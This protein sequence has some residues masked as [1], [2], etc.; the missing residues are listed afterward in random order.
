MA[1]ATAIVVRGWDG[2]FLL[3]SLP[4]AFTTVVLHGT[5]LAGG[6]LWIARQFLFRIPFPTQPGHWLLLGLAPLS[7]SAAVRGVP[8]GYWWPTNLA[9]HLVQ[10]AIFCL[11]VR[12][13]FASRSWQTCFG[14]LAVVFGLLTIYMAFKCLALRY[15]QQEFIPP[16]ASW[17][18]VLVWVIAFCTAGIC[19]LVGV[20]SDFAPGPRRDWLHYVGALLPVVVILGF[21]GDLISVGVL[22]R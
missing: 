5:L 19:W 1:A 12:D 18:A 17:A 22:F 10:T 16:L 20:L 6:A 21:I 9:V 14:A 15:P 11:A 8:E 3:R 13:S 2:P 4:A 7:L